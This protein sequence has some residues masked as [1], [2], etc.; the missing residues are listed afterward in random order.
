MDH[1]VLSFKFLPL[2]KVKVKVLC[3]VQQ[4]ESYWDR[5]SGLPL[6][7]LEPTEVTTYY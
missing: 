1:K 2:L 4:S 3:P 6:V 5:P 7:G